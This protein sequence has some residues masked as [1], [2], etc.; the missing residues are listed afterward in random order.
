M[1]V[2]AHGKDSLSRDIVFIAVSIAVAVY[3][4]DTGVLATILAGLGGVSY[5]G[6]FVSGLFFTSI[7]TT[8]PAIVVLG[9]LTEVYGIVPVAVFGAAGAVVGDF[10]LFKYIRD[11]FADHLLELVGHRH[12]GRKLRTFFHLRLFRWLSIFIGG[13]IISSPLPDELAM[14]IFGLSKLRTSWFIPLS[15]AFNF[16]GIILIGLVVQGV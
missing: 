13:L 16:L 3:L 7:F 1:S 4:V 5:L 9:Q 14:G 11:R 12:L 2:H 8:A 6:S 15:Y 10:V